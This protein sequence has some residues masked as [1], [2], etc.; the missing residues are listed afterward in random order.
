MTWL[1]RLDNRQLRRLGRSLQHEMAHARDAAQDRLR[2][3][4]DAA[5][6]IAANGLDQATGYGRREG[7]AFARTA[8]AQAG[9]AARQIA[10]LGQSEGVALARTAAV[11]AGRAARQVAEFGQN[12]GTVLARSAALEAKRAARAIRADPVPALVAVVGVAL[13][14]RLLMSRPHH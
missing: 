3:F 13:L 12:E 11:Q 10:E 14:A 9:H 2:H 7:A 6:P 4:A 1:E 5:A 8:A